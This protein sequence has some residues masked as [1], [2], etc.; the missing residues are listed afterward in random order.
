MKALLL[1]LSA[2]TLCVNS[3]PVMA[4]AKP[5]SKAMGDASFVFGKLANGAIVGFFGQMSIFEGI[6]KEQGLSKQVVGNPNDATF[7]TWEGQSSS[8]RVFASAAFPWLFDKTMNRLQVLY[9]PPTE[10]PMPESVL[11]HLLAKGERTKID[12]GDTIE[13]TLPMEMA[14]GCRVTR[15]ITLRMTTGALVYNSMEVF[16]PVK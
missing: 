16:C 3:A 11:S 14:V 1:L 10:M 6:A 7:A 9:Q 13:I 4:Q 8:G 15:M 2:A 12:S 5:P